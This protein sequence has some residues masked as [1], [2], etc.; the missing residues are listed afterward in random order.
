MGAADMVQSGLMTMCKS[1]FNIDPEE[2]KQAMV[3]FQNMVGDI[4]I[5]LT[6]IHNE[7]VAIRAMLERMDNRIGGLDDGDGNRRQVDGL[8]K[9]GDGVGNNGAVKQIGHR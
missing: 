4:Q 7:Q 8:G 3:V 5:K 1:L 2:M 6:A 9:P